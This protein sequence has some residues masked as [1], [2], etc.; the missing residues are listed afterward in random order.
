MVDNVV[1]PVG[2]YHFFKKTK[3]GN[4]AALHENT[5]LVCFSG[6][7]LLQKGFR[8]IDGTGSNRRE[9]ADI[10]CIIQQAVFC[11]EGLF[12]S[13]AKVADDFK[14]K[15]TDAKRFQEF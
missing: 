15:K 3:Q 10:Y 5:V 4:Q 9:K 13:F 11:L 2:D 7:Q 14:C 8:R 12:V 6:F 1:K